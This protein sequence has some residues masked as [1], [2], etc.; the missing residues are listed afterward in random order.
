RPALRCADREEDSRNGAPSSDAC[1]TQPGV[2]RLP[3]WKQT[4][5]CSY[6]STGTQVSSRGLQCGWGPSCAQD[7]D[8][9]QAPVAQPFTIVTIRA[10][11]GQ[12]SLACHTAYT[13]RRAV[14]RDSPWNRHALVARGFG[15]DSCCL[16]HT[17]LHTHPLGANYPRRFSGLPKCT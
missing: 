7:V 2:K 1:R 6:Q 9:T 12:R 10:K 17:A 3:Q 5:S 15:H 13:R 4:T 11:L 8:P 14:L 16:L